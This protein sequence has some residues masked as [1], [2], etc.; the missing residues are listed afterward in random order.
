MS[1][2]PIDLAKTLIEN[3]E[4][5]LELVRIHEFKDDSEAHDDEFT[6]RLHEEFSAD[7]KRAQKD[8]SKIYGKPVRTGTDDDDVIPLN[9]VFCFAVWAVGETS[10]YIAAAHEDRGVP[11]LLM[12]GTSPSEG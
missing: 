12:V 5:G 10:L 1:T 3:G 9:G 4:P 11:V 7:L 8:L 2:S 6:E